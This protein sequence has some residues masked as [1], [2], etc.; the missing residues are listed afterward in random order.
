MAKFNVVGLDDVQEAMLRQDAIVEEAVPEML[1]AGGA[2]MQKAQQEEIKTRFNSRRS[3]GALL[4]SI[5]VSAVKE[6]D[7][8]KRVEIYPNGKDKHGV[9]NAEKGFVLNYGRSN[10]PARAFGRKSKMKNVDSLLK[11]ELEKLGVPVERLKYGGKAACFIVYQL[12][13]GRDTFFSDD[14]EGAQEFTYQVHVYSKTDYIDILQRLKTALKAAG[15]Y[16]ITIDA[17]TY[18]Q[19]TGYYH[20]PVEIKYMEV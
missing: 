7:G 20:V 18:E 3:T 17:E 1:K 12:V 2:V 16:A 14:E 11:A 10:M 8:G 5:K 4:A 6:I 19:D 9:R 13:V 15:F